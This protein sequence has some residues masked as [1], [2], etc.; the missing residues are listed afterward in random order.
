MHAQVKQ[1]IEA[2]KKNAAEV[3]NEP[4][5]KDFINSLLY[6]H[7]LPDGSTSISDNF[8]KFFPLIYRVDKDGNWFIRTMYSDTGERPYSFEKAMGDARIMYTG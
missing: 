6:V 7:S 2:V 4:D 8:E 1:F 5:D 3:W